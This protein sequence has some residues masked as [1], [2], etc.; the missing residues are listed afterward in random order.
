MEP[1]PPLS[2][3]FSLLLQDEKQRKVGTRKVLVDASAALA[4]FGSKFG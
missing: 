4:A 1:M 3:V 2:K